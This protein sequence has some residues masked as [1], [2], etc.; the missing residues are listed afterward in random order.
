[1]WA[2]TRLQKPAHAARFPPRCGGQQHKASSVASIQ[3]PQSVR[4]AQHLGEGSEFWLSTVT[5]CTLRELVS[6]PLYF[7]ENLCA[8]LLLCFLCE[9]AQYNH[10]FLVNLRL[11]TVKVWKVRLYIITTILGSHGNCFNYSRV[12][13]QLFMLTPLKD[14]G[15]FFHFSW[16][17]LQVK[18]VTYNDHTSQGVNY[19]KASRRNFTFYPQV[20]Q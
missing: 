12:H 2:E 10:Y 9:M 15:S 14:S 8:A 13:W 11:L 6:G 20:W 16:L 7:P 17:L 3:F 19:G 1:M 18:R 5:S 4:D